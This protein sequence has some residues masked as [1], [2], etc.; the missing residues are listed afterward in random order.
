MNSRNVDTVLKLPASVS[1]I[2]VVD[3]ILAAPDIRK[4]PVIHVESDMLLARSTILPQRYYSRI[5]IKRIT[6]KSLECPNCFIG[7]KHAGR[8]PVPLCCRSCA[9]DWRNLV[10]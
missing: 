1:P 8:R 4:L 5:S 3:P 7:R 2:A 10:I 9:S 6:Y